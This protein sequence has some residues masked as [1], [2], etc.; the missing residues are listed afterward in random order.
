M[1]GLQ[2]EPGKRVSFNAPFLAKQKTAIRLTNKENWPIMYR[3]SLTSPKR[4]NIDKMNGTLAVEASTLVVIYL[5][6][7]KFR[8]GMRDVITIEYCRIPQDYSLK[9]DEKFLSES[10]VVLRRTLPVHFNL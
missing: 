6:A 8:E 7:L 9:F 4:Y 5:N 1:T 3:I 10:D 2:L